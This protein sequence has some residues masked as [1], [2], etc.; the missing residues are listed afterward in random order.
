MTW[1]NQEIYQ[2]AILEQ[3]ESALNSNN[4]KGLYADRA[5]DG[6]GHHEHHLD[7]GQ[8]VAINAVAALAIEWRGEASDVRFDCSQ[9]ECC[10]GT[11]S[12]QDFF[13]GQSAL[14]DPR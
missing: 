5:S 13:S 6:A 7:V 9:D 14:P 2:R 1:N 3:A 11:Q 12:A 8:Y 4:I 10:G